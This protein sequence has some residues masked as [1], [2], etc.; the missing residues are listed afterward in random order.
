[1]P[2]L[3]PEDRPCR[4][5]AKSAAHKTLAITAL[6]AAFLWAPGPVGAQEVRPV[7]YVKNVDGLVNLIRD[8]R[9]ETLEPGAAIFLEDIIESGA[10]GSFGITLKD[11]TRLSGGPNT[12]LKIKE[13]AF[14]PA[15]G[16]LGSIMEVLK[17]TLFYI[18][19]TISKLS[20]EAVKI[21][22]PFG[23]IAVRGTRFVVRVG[24][25]ES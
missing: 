24:G 14:E 16:K 22:T 3:F 19:G 1:M 7:G 6:A 5:F 18:S 8:Q 12:K 15:E 23:L 2:R 4:W 10:D 9:S 13:F 17:G 11:D 25:G 21:E 20:S